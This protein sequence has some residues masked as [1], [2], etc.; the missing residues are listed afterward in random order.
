MTNKQLIEVLNR[1]RSND[2]TAD[3]L[4]SWLKS[5]SLTVSSSLKRSS[6]LKLKQGNPLAACKEALCLCE[7]CKNIFPQGNF[8]SYSAFEDCDDEIKKNRLL[9]NIVSIHEPH[10]VNLLSKVIGGS[11]FFKCSHCGSIWQIVLP[12]RVQKGSWNRIA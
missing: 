1:Y 10:F 11:A 9:N 12:E 8:L 6:Y 4:H 3:D 7:H 5:N 2:I